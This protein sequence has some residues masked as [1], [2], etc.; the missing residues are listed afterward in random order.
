MQTTPTNIMKHHLHHG[1]FSHLYIQHRQ[2]RV[3]LN[4][5][6]VSIC[7]YSVYIT[8]NTSCR[9]V[10]LL[11]I[12][13]ISH[14][15]YYIKIKRGFSRSCSTCCCCFTGCMTFKSI[16]N[17]IYSNTIFCYL[18]LVIPLK[19]KASIHPLS[20]SSFPLQGRRS[21]RQSTSGQ[22]I[23]LSQG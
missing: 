2:Q 8:A 22:V 5:A 13:L 18:Q 16:D 14:T 20:I 12:F 11:Y 10:S 3:T 4:I 15:V 7:F 9:L 17:K 23:S 1:N 19:R 6:S 21:E